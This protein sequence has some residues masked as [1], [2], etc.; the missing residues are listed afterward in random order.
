MVIPGEKVMKELVSTITTKGQATI[1]VEV[2]RALGV[3]PRDKLVFILDGRDVRLQR[4]QSVIERTA[5]AV[6]PRGRP[7]SAGE[8]RALA[9]DL[10]AS[11]A[12]KRGRG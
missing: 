5:G 1:P 4:R 3:G 2:R 12:M 10:I 8:E 6:K 9:E 7:L 11:E